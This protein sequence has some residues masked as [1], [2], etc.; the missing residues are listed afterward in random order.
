MKRLIYFGTKALHRAPAWM[1]DAAV[2]G[3]SRFTGNVDD[4]KVVSNVPELTTFDA[5]SWREP[6]LPRAG[7]RNFVELTTK[8]VTSCAAV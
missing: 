7:W 6:H 8:S 3:Y 5:L 4:I 1:R 2:R